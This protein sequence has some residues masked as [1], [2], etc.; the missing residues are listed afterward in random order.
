MA[1]FHAQTRSNNVSGVPGVHFHKTT[2]QPLGF[3]QATIHLSD[4]RRTAKSFSVRK[5]GNDEAFQLAVAARAKM[6][7]MVQ[8]RPYL[9]HPDAKEA[10]L[11]DEGRK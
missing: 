8:D 10:A 3:W 11:S 1:E 7:A 6:L 5:H 2:S 9:Y 4:K